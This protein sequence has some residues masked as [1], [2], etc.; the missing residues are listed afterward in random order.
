MKKN[1]FRLPIVLLVV[2]MGSCISN[3][4]LIYMQ[5]K[6]NESPLVSS[7]EII[8]YQNAEYYLQPFDIVDITI[9]TRVPE[10]NELFTLYSSGSQNMAMMS[11]GSQAGGDAFFMNGYALSEDGFIELPLVGKVKAVGLTTEQAQ[12]LIEQEVG[13]YVLDG[14]YFVRVRLGGIRFSALG[15]FNSPGKITILQNRVTIFEA[16][17]AAN[18]LSILAKRDELVLVRQYPEG[19]Q[20]HRVNLNDKN[21]LGSEYYFVRPNDVIYAEPLKVREIGNTTNFIQSLTLITTTVTAVALIL[22]L[23]NNK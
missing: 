6:G 5:D 2:V 21:L 18:D 22:T 3:E 11:G 4:R 23:I 20:I 8:G 14:E 15:E 17:A 16:I 12:A 19:S 9:K 7:S 10:I 1:L 13:K